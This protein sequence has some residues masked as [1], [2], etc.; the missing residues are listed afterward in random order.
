MTNTIEIN[1]NDYISEEDRRQVARDVFKAECARHAQADFE[2]ILSNSAY[3]MVGD[4]VNQHFD[5]SMIEVLKANAI[6]VINNLS[7]V[8]VFSPPSAWDRAA[9]KGFTFMQEAL[10]E[11]KPAIHKRVHEVI[12]G[13]N[14]EDLREIIERQVGE[15]IIAKL[16]R[17]DGDG[18]PL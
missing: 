18:I 15:A 8:T 10:E 16:T 5:G 7:S 12:A 13:Y 9:S 14:S 4:L 2:R 11:L 6:R 17:A 3:F 1:L